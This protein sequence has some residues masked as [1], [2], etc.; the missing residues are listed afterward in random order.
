MRK[1]ADDRNPV[2][3]VLST[4]VD[5]THE[6]KP[7]SKTGQPVF[8]GSSP[9]GFA[10]PA[11]DRSYVITCLFS[12]YCE[13][14]RGIRRASEPEPEKRI[15]HSALTN[16]CSAAALSVR[17]N[18]KGIARPVH[19]AESPACFPGTS[20][21]GKLFVQPQQTQC[22]H[23]DKWNDNQRSIPTR[24]KD[25]VVHLYSPSLGLEMRV[26]SSLR[27]VHRRRLELP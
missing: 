21:G 6:C 26:F 9:Q 15:A 4:Q 14:S 10:T 27:S 25:Y 18:K 22:R 8:L 13:R 2:V 7:D 19:L 5:G 20:R 16:N 11:R 24:C 1:A 17:I 12:L 3:A 23:S